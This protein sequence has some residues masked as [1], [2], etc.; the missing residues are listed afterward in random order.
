LIEGALLG[1]MELLGECTL[2]ADKVV[3]F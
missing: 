1:G 2:V 3:A